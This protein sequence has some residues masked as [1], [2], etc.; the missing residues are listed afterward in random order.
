MDEYRVTPTAEERAALGRPVP[1]GKG[2]ARRPTRARILL[3]ADAEAAGGR[4]DDEIVAALG[5][6]TCAAGRVRRRPAAA[7]FP[8]A[9]DPSPQPQRPDEIEIPGDVERR[10]IRL[11]RGGPPEGR[12]HWTLQPL[13]DESVASGLVEAVGTGT[14][15]RALKKTTS[16]RGSSRLGASRPRRTPTTPGGWKARSRRTG[17]P[18]I[19]TIP[20]SASTGRAGN[21]AARCGRPGS[22][23]RGARPGWVTGTSGRGPVAGC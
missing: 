22:P 9:L 1:T 3:P 11:A 10:L 4:T 2:A 19:R 6:G 14:V 16:S 7:G 21:C 13:A 15:R 20:R 8:A 17:C 12:C 5:A 18:T 23:G